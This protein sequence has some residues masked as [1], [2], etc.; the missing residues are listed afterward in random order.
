MPRLHSSRFRGS[1]QGSGHGSRQREYANTSFALTA[2]LALS[3]PDAPV[4]SGKLSSASSNITGSAS[5]STCLHSVKI[6]LSHK[7]VKKNV[8]HA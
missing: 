2:L 5:V 6:Q 7:C 4:T 3:L 1:E 8:V